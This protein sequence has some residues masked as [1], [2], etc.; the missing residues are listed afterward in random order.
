MPNR[1]LALRETPITF[2]QSGG[3]ADFNPSGKVNNTGRVSNR[4]DRGTLATSPRY[5]WRAKTRCATAPAIGAILKVYLVTSDG[6]D[7]DGEI[8]VVGGDLPTADRLRNLTPIGVVVADE[9][10]STRFF[11][12]SGVVEILERYVQV[13]WY[14]EFGVALS[15]T[16]TDHLFTLTAAPDEIQ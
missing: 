1:I 8:N 16:T 11:I 2:K 14:N 7:A 10:S 12:A 15:A 6:T 4:W 13:V 5:I 3:T 9:A